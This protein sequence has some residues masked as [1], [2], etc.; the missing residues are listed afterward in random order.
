MPTPPITIIGSLNTDLITRTPRLPHPGETLTATSFSTGCGGKGCNPAVACARLSRSSSSSSSPP[1]S[2]DTP[3]LI[4]TRMLGA[5]GD[6]EFGSTLIEGLQRNGVD[7]S[8]VS[9][10]KGQRTGVAVIVV[11]EDTG[12]NRIL[13]TP[14]ANFSVTPG[15]LPETL[16][17]EGKKEE[18][19]KK[20]ALVILQLEI[21][22]ET[23]V[24]VCKRARA[25]GVPVLLNPAPAPA[26]GKKGLPVDVFMG[27]EHLILNETEAG[28]LSG[29]DLPPLSPSSPYDKDRL[30]E[31]CH[32]FHRL[33]VMNVILTLGARGVYWS[34]SGGGS[35]KLDNGF[36]PATT[37]PNVVDT[38]AAGDTFVGAYAV[39][40]VLLSGEE[41][42]EGDGSVRRAVEWAN[43]AAGKCV[44]K[45]G[46]MEAIPWRGEVG[47]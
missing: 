29:L 5:V 10:V 18:E 27:L 41:E 40:V 43:R 36:I 15:S 12:E 22:L 4:T 1:S 35:S 31:I 46:A 9:V 45:E 30:A 3:S 13:L 42:E 20:P 23:V 34:S 16:F 33:G 2:G 7:A 39:A 32:H 14:G 28:M 25:N 24:H 21:P 37:V 11:E 19:K 17:L 6:D 38:T 47:L 26:E 44:M 8:D